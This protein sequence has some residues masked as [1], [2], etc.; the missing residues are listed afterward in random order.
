M[1]AKYSMYPTSTNTPAGCLETGSR[2][3]YVKAGTLLVTA[4][5]GFHCICIQHSAFAKASL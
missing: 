3:A 2:E 5:P 1:E 4:H